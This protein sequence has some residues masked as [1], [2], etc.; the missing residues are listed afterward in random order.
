[1]LLVASDGILLNRVKNSVVDEIM[2]YVTASEDAIRNGKATPARAALRPTRAR[3]T[4]A[5]NLSGRKPGQALAGWRETARVRAVSQ[6]DPLEMPS[7]ADAAPG[8]GD[9]P[10]PA[11]RVFTPSSFPLPSVRVL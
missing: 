10:S 4:A 3:G 1:M 5:S 6:R 9:L 11:P 2:R 8:I 7:P